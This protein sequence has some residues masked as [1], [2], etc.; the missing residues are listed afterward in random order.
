MTKRV[1]CDGCL[2]ASGLRAQRKVR[3]QVNQDVEGAVG[4]GRCSVAQAQ[5]HIAAV[6]RHEGLDRVHAHAAARHRGNGGRGGKA[7]REDE[8]RQRLVFVLVVRLDQAGLYGLG[9]DALQI[10]AAAV[11]GHA[12]LQRVGVQGHVDDDAPGRGLA[13]AQ[14]GLGLFDAVVH[15]VAQQVREHVAQCACHLV[16]QGDAGIVN[17]HRRRFLVQV[18]RQRGQ[19]GNGAAQRVRQA[20][21][22][23]QLQRVGHF[24]GGSLQRLQ[25]LSSKRN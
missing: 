8:L 17:V 15:R 23:A 21:A 11:V 7:R 9:A 16:V 14:A 2:Q 18:C 13:F 4:A 12:Q 6:G 5:C 19:G 3:R 25:R 24:C 1:P 22:G 20:H 10:Q